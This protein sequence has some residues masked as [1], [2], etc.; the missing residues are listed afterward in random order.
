MNDLFVY[1]S[2]LDRDILTIVLGEK[3]SWKL[4]E[5]VVLRG[6]CAVYARNETFPILVE[7]PEECVQGA[8]LSNLNIED[9]K[10]LDFFEDLEEYQK[11]VVVIESS[12]GDRNATVYFPLDT[13]EVT[14]RRWSYLEWEK[15]YLPHF[16]AQTKNY[17]AGYENLEQVKW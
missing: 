12:L 4:E 2:L 10:R 16:I 6:Y 8:R 14:N 1:G 7:S 15:L 5:N 13:L 9:W 17:M 11:K 3:S